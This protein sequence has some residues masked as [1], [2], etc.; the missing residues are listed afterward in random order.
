MIVRNQEAVG[1]YLNSCMLLQQNTIIIY[2]YNWLVLA[3]SSAA[4]VSDS[5]AALS[6]FTDP[7]FTPFIVTLSGMLLLEFLTFYCDTKE[8]S[9]NWFY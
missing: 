6:S 5:S 4:A 2:Y 7:N 8:E 1:L 9:K 3:L